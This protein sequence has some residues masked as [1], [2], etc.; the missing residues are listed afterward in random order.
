MTLCLNTRS[1][2]AGSVFIILCVFPASNRVLVPPR[3]M[4][5]ILI[6]LIFF[7]RYLPLQICKDVDSVPNTLGGKCVAEL[8]L[9][10]VGKVTS[11][12]VC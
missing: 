9:W 6:T 10:G 12:G 11:V 2:K 3:L 7:G 4:P 1:H 5:V 8:R